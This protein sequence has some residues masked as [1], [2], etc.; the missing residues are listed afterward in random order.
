[1]NYWMKSI[2]WGIMARL[3]PAYHRRAV[4]KDIDKMCAAF[5]LES[6]IQKALT[7]KYPTYGEQERS[8]IAVPKQYNET[9]RWD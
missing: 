3:F 4:Q 6:P 7:D 5:F 8:S 1:M 2:Y 9:P